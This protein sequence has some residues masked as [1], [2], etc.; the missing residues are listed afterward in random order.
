VRFLKGEEFERLLA[1]ASPAL[2]PALVLAVET[3]PRKEE[4]LGLVVADIDLGRREVHLEPT[5]TD[6]RRRVTPTDPALVTIQ[7]LVAA[8]GRRVRIVTDHGW[9]LMPGGLE[10]AALDSVLT[11]PNGKRSRNA[12]LKSGA[13]TSYTRLP[14]TWDPAVS[15]AVATGARTF[16]RARFA[17]IP[18]IVMTTSCSAVP[19][20]PLQ[21]RQRSQVVR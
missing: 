6:T 13:P 18:W 20:V 16:F 21:A 9:L 8:Q 5:K 12:A 11:E 3:G 2:R 15:L 1:A 4:L 7:E 19:V 17:P 14:W 10:Q